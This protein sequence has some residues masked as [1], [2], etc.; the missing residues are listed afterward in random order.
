[1]KDQAIKAIKIGTFPP[2]FG[3]PG[4]YLA[5]ALQDG[6]YTSILIEQ[7]LTVNTFVK[8]LKFLIYELKYSQANEESQND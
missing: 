8:R 4:E 6:K 3:P 7:P 1:M 2:E 5:V